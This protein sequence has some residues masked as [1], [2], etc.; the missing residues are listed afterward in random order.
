MN[1]LFYSFIITFFAL[2]SSFL[3]SCATVSECI[4]YTNVEACRETPRGDV[5]CSYRNTNTNEEI[6][7][8]KSQWEEEKHGRLSLR[9][10]DFLEIRS[11]LRI[12]EKITCDEEE[13]K[14]EVCVKLKR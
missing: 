1:R 8:D 11:K 7:V 12:L 14:E 2:T 5:F 9:T 10:S 4:K 6:Q 3:I 13:L